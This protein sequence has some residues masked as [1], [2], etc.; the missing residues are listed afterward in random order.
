MQ[1]SEVVGRSHEREECEIHFCGS[2]VI[3]LKGDMF[4][5]ARRNHNIRTANKS[6]KIVTKFK[7]VQATVRSKNYVHDFKST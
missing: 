3:I 6:F 2:V 5:N 4:M 1:R 7:Y